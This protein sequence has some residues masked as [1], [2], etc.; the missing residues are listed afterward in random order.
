VNHVESAGLSRRELEVI[1][2]VA[3]GR[4]N[5]GIGR[6]LFLS[7]R[8]VDMHVRNVL[9]KLGARS[10]GE[11]SHRAHQLGLLLTPDR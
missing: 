5:Q 8:T 1:R 6:N 2:Q 7:T 10:R 3:V 11:A 9:A 4:T